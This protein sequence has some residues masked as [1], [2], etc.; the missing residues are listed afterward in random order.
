MVFLAAAPLSSKVVILGTIFFCFEF[1]GAFED[2]KKA[3]DVQCLIQKLLARRGSP[4]LDTWLVLIE[5]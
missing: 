2:L 1:I 4:A 5:T 3:R